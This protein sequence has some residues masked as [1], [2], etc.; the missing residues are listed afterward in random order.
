MSHITLS[1]QTPL[2]IREADLYLDDFYLPEIPYLPSSSDSQPPKDNI[3]NT[4]R[5][6]NGHR[7][8]IIDKP[9]GSGTIEV[10]EVSQLRDHIDRL[11]RANRNLLLRLVGRDLKQ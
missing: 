6:S 2:S 10:T 4:S 1:F 8:A 3:V 7:P 11:E 9:L 5:Q